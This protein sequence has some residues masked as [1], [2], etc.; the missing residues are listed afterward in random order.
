MRP[1]LVTAALFLATTGGLLAQEHTAGHAMKADQ[2]KW[3][4]G[5]PVLPKGAEF[6]VLSGDPG[7][8]GPFTMRLKVPAGYKIPAHSHPT[9]ERVT[10]I[11]GNFHVGMGDKLDEAKTDSLE[12]GGFVDLPANMNHY[13]F[14]STGTIVQINSEGPFVIKYVNPADDPSKAQ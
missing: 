11:S 9:A 3:M 10:V 4:P 7:K 8:P 1:V 13:A 12:T 5:P 2:L 6:A 14:M